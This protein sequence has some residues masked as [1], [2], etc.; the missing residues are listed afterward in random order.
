MSLRASVLFLTENSEKDY[1]DYEQHNNIH[2]PCWSETNLIR[3][4]HD[5][6]PYVP[7]CVDLQLFPI[8]WM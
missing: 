5:I 6:Q 7:L 8:G 3:T 2:L 4:G 1:R